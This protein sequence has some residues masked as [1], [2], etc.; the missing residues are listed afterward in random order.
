MLD[1]FKRGSSS[2]SGV[3]PYRFAVGTNVI[4][5]T[6]Q[7]EWSAGVI[8]ALNYRE[9]HWPPGKIV[10]Y[11]VQLMKGPLIFVPADVDQLCR[12]LVPPWWGSCFKKSKSLYA[13]HNP[14]AQ[15]IATE[16]A[17]KDVN[18]TDHEG[19]TALMEA[20]TKAW[21][22]AVSQLLSM[23][24]DPDVINNDNSSAI[25][26]AVAQ[27]KEII[28]LLVDAKANLNCQDQ[29]PDYDPEFTSTTFGDRLEHRTPLHYVCLEGDAES[30]KL[31][32]EAK[33]EVDMRDAQ[34]KTPLHLAIDED[35]ADCVDLLLRFGA[36]M[37]LGNQS[38]GMESSALMDAASAGKTKLVKKL[39]AAKADINKKGKQ[40]LSA[41]HLAARSRRA[42]V[43]EVLLAAK[44]DMNQESKLG[45]PLQLARK[46][47]GADLLKVFD[48][49]SDLSGT[50]NNISSLDAAQ[51]AALFMD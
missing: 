29:D 25:H 38:C 3:S 6:G 32:L 12:K 36:D 22:N 33:A 21:P 23:K 47:G 13:E 41:L 30:A 18:A 34:Y 1:M 51:R 42:D 44:A 9:S 20:V 48:V 5:R 37:N 16:G 26:M 24:A 14:S 28:Q 43:C 7:N 4:C 15:A 46:N 8:V 2:G 39:V 17:G 31:L 10:P 49:Q 27:G 40:Q 45:T 19:N 50:V 35:K 11:Q